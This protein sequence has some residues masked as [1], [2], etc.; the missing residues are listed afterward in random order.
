MTCF[1]TVTL[2]MKLNLSETWID[3][4]KHSWDFYLPE[5]DINIHGPYPAGLASR[6]PWQPKKNCEQETRS[7]NSKLVALIYF[8]FSMMVVTLKDCHHFCFVARMIP[9]SVSATSL[10][11]NAAKNLGTFSRVLAMQRGSKTKAKMTIGVPR[12]EVGKKPVI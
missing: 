12:L 8:W 10:Q 1:K 5:W 6:S 2:D 11:G 3:L 4:W 9:P 7:V